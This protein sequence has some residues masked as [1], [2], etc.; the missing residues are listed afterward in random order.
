[1]TKRFQGEQMTCVVCGK[2]VYSDPN[3]SSGWTYIEYEGQG[4]FVCP[5]ELEVN[6]YGGT[7][8]AYERVL[9]VI[10]RKVDR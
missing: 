2:Q 10:A 6:R 9:R 4:F 1:M 8:Q 3:V 5:A 7:K